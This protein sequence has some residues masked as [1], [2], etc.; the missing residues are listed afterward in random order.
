[1]WGRARWGRGFSASRGGCGCGGGGFIVVLTV[2]IVMSIFNADLGIG[3]S[4]RIPLTDSNVTVAGSIGAKERAPDALPVYTHGRLGG[5]QNFVNYSTT[6][7]LGPAEG[8]A[9]LVI[10]K[11]A[12]APVV[13]LH[14]VLTR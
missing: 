13:D 9:L 12:G 5:N 3:A 2:G 11:Q 8:T 7:T 4:V 6:L 10:G 14:L 1:M